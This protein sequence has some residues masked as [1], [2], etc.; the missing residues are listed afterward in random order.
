MKAINLR[1]YAAAF[2]AL[3]WLAGSSNAH[4]QT[5]AFSY[6]HAY[7]IPSQAKID[8]VVNNIAIVLVIPKSALGIVFEQGEPDSL[9]L[10]AYAQGEEASRPR[11]ADPERGEAAQNSP[12]PA[13]G[14][15]HD[16]PQARHSDNI[17]PLTGAAGNQPAVVNAHS[18]D[19]PNEESASVWVF[20]GREGFE[21]PVDPF[22]AIEEVALQETE[23]L[24]DQAVE[25]AAVPEESVDDADAGA[26]DEGE[27]MSTAAGRPSDMG[28]GSSGFSALYFQHDA[29]TP[30]EITQG[31]ADDRVIVKFKSEGEYALRADP[32]ILLESGEPFQYYVNSGSQSLD[33]LKQALQLKGARPVF[34]EGWREGLRTDEAQWVQSMARH[35][36][37]EK[38]EERSAR[39][40]GDAPMPDLTNTYVVYVPDNVDIKK[41]CEY[42]QSDPHVEYAVPDYVMRPEV[43]P[44]DPP[45]DTFYASFQWALENTGQN[46]NGQ[47]GTAD[48]D[49]DASAAWPD[50]LGNGIVVA[51]VD[52]GMVL[53]HED[54]DAQIWSNPGETAGNGIDD[55]ANGFVDDTRGW[56]FGNDDSNPTDFDG[57][58]THVSGTI[59]AEANN[60]TG[61]I[62][63]APG[64]KI[65]P[66]K[67]FADDGTGFTSDLAAA[68]EYAAMN[69]ADVINNSWGCSSQCPSN[70]VV[71]DAVRT[72]HGLGA[73]VVFAAGNDNQNV[74]N[75]SPNN[76]TEPI[77]V[78]GSD[79]RDDRYAFSNFGATVDVTA[80]AVDVGSTY[81]LDSPYFGYA[82]STGTSMAAPHVSGVA[83]L[84]LEVASDAG[85][86]I[87]N[88]QVEAIIRQTAEDV[89]IANQGTGRLNAALATDFTNVLPVMSGGVD[90]NVETQSNLSFG[91]S[92]SDPN[93]QTATLT[94][95]LSIG[96]A[97]TTIGATFTDNGN[98]TG[99][100]SW[101]PTD[102][103][104]GSNPTIVFTAT[105]PNGFVDTDSVNITV[106][107]RQYCGDG[108]VDIGEECDD[109]N[110]TS[111]DGCTAACVDEFC[112]DGVENDGAS[113][114]CDDGNVANGDGCS[115]TCQLESCGD[116]VVDI[117]EECDDSNLVSGDGC[118]SSCETEVCGNSRVDF[119]ESCDDGN[120]VSGDGCTAACVD[121]FC[122]D[123]V[124]NN[125]SLEQ[126]DD[127][128]AVSGD[129]C[130]SMCLTE[131]C[132]DGVV[133]NNGTEECDD[134]N[135]NEADGCNSMCEYSAIC[136]NGSCDYGIGETC[137]TC[138]ADCGSCRGGSRPAP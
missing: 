78:G 17:S 89:G 122:G 77:V 45:N 120:L 109:G 60:A 119:G 76:M 62:G 80:P 68:V 108:T 40:S 22:E 124:D 70:P 30:Q 132:G 3:A 24:P 23:I 98:N 133:N 91:V 134:G 55:D 93:G 126:C 101:T 94:A 19:Y 103:Q 18:N 47:T 34:G 105:D 42:L 75:W 53:T 13:A 48:A 16:A 85:M 69:G 113:E 95:A 102:G 86:S 27:G 74:S 128:N 51:V 135:E 137:R 82:F 110:N 21:S 56:D 10:I 136:G 125:G 14:G 99:T 39:V 59:A 130:S 52:T 112:G 114:Q 121:E 43:F 37:A 104:A 83:A 35:S 54:L 84:I 123:G 67:G 63:V 11:T 2:Y 28:H 20:D 73:V 50:A 117:G 46:V 131:F 65:M 92:A 111:G 38:F 36:A 41:V 58:G 57:H 15:Q 115:S 87:T 127:G 9:V 118:S 7:N 61:V 88:E 72:A 138:W 64:V 8:Q 96:G 106:T 12:A 4:A 5:P 97:V 129:G 32:G 81:L 71:E 44:N 29:P 25:S 79:N 116:G 6:T 107:L 31:F 26:A 100:F 49:I 1:K 33:Q 66:V 90:R